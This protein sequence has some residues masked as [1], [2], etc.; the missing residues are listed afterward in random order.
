MRKTCT[1]LLLCVICISVLHGC[2]K[3]P[4]EKLS[5]KNGVYTALGIESYIFKLPSG[6][7]VQNYFTFTGSPK[8]FVVELLY[9]TRDGKNIGVVEYCKISP[10]GYVAYTNDV[11]MYIPTDDVKKVQTIASVLVESPQYMSIED[12]K[13]YIPWL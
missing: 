2:T 3:I 10:K 13:Q 4:A 5:N 1:L 8:Q 11:V 12:A 6:K 7:S 9:H